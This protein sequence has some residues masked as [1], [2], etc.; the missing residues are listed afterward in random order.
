MEAKITITYADIDKAARR[1]IEYLGS[2]G[3]AQ[4]YE[5]MLLQAEDAEWFDEEHNDMMA[6]LMNVLETWSVKVEDTKDNNVVTGKKVTLYVPD[7]V[8]SSVEGTVQRK[9]FAFCVSFIESKW[10]QIVGH[11]MA[12]VRATEA[13]LHLKTIRSTMTHRRPPI[14]R[15]PPNPINRIGYAEGNDA[16]ITVSVEVDGVT[17]IPNSDTIQGLE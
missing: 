6:T 16:D 14:R 15:T 4:G 3:T 1:Y 13:E 2:K 7:N 17:V 12:D 11:D 8:R 10:L 9:A 5:R